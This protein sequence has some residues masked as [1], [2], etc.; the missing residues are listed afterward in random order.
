MVT[1]TV[2]IGTSDILE[3]CG[4]LEEAA[5]KLDAL[6]AQLR[7]WNVEGYKMNRTDGF[8]DGEYTIFKEDK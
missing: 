4:T 1:R 7:Q 2:T 3:G 8:K 5:V 6:A